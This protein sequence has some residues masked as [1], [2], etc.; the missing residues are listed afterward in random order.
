MAKGMFYGCVSVF[1]AV[2]S[3]KFFFRFCRREM[4]VLQKYLLYGLVEFEV[5]ALYCSL[6]WVQILVNETWT[7]FS[8]FLFIPLLQHNL[9]G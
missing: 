4:F 5:G 7:A 9:A 2:C 8:S 3:N 6:C 1:F